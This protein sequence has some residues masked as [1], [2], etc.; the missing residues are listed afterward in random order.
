M[1]LTERLAL[2]IDARTGGAVRDIQKVQREVGA[3]QAP[4]TR[5][6]RALQGLGLSGMVSGQALKAGLGTAAV[7]G[8]FGLAAL[9]KEAVAASSALHEQQTATEEIFGSGAA[10]VQDFADRADGAFGLSER[11][12]LEAANQYAIFFDQLGVGSKTVAEL[13]TTMVGLGQDITSLR[14]IPQGEAQTRL[15]SGLAGEMEAVRRLGIDLSDI[16]VKAEAAALGF[17]PINGQ[18][19]QQAKIAARLSLILKDTEVAQGNFA[20]TSGDLAN[21]QRTLG[22]E[23]ENLSASLGDSLVPAVTATVHGLSDLVA[24]GE[25]VIGVVGKIGAGISDINDALGGLPGLFAGGPLISGANQIRAIG[26]AVGI[27]GDESDD[28]SSAVDSQKNSIASLSASLPG[29]A[30]GYIQV[31][32][33]QAEFN[34]GLSDVRGAF[35]GLLDAEDAHN[36]ALSRV[37]DASRDAAQAHHDLADAQE[38]QRRTIAD[39]NIEVERNERAVVRASR[40]VANAQRD[41]AEANEDL[42]EAQA[43]YDKVLADFHPDSRRA[44]EALEDLEDAQRRQEDAQF[45]AED[46]GYALIEAQRNLADTTQQLRDELDGVGPAADRVRDAQDRVRESADDLREAQDNVARSAVELEIQ[47]AETRDTLSEQNYEFDQLIGWLGLLNDKYPGV[48]DGMLWRAALLRG[49]LENVNEELSQM[50]PQLDALRAL[51]EQP[52]YSGSSDDRERQS[53]LPDAYNRTIGVDE[54]G[55]LTDGKAR[56]GGGGWGGKSGDWHIH[57][58]EKIDPLHAARETKRQLMPGG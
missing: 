57:Y 13:S 23:V 44:H 30:R 25:P 3:L 4:V 21:S 47:M 15:L 34:E 36:D 42:A 35:F 11:A 56:R 43:E 41:L 29:L 7:A 40:A 45:S 18:F 32:Q 38:D 55:N 9:G 54:D 28:T 8:A 58:H 51:D 22:A 5:T 46:A 12:A 27:L 24:V 17:E 19:S 53:T 39:L 1:A 14:D 50:A 31:T 48:F 16:K 6:D 49:E 10:V 2:I 26:S 33:T 52:T 37:D 20:K